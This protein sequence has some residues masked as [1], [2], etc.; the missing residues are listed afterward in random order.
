MNG[1][2]SQTL[3]RNIHNNVF[4]TKS[5]YINQLLQQGEARTSLTNMYGNSIWGKFLT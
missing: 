3:F 5:N 2:S 4:Y 1:L